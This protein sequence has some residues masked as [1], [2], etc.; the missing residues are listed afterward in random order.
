[1]DLDQFNLRSNNSVEA[2]VGDGHGGWFIGGAF[3]SVGGVRCPALAHILANASVDRSWCTKLRL[4]ALTNNASTEVAALVRRGQ[5]LLVGGYFASV[6]GKRRSGLAAVTISTGA[7][8]AW[9]PRLSEADCLQNC[10]IGS[11]SS[12]SVQGSKVYLA[13]FFGAVDG[14]KRY[15]LAAVDVHSGRE[16]G[17]NPTPKPDGTITDVVADGGVVYVSGSFTRVGGRHLDCFAALN[18]ATGKATSFRIPG[19]VLSTVVHK[20]ILYASGFI[21]GHYVNAFD[22]PSGRRLRWNPPLPTNAEREVPT[23]LDVSGGNVYIGHGF[24]HRYVVESFAASDGKKRLW[25]SPTLTN[26][27]DSIGISRSVIIL[28]GNFYGIVR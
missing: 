4:R 5:L 26:N 19:C 10:G 7:V 15:R 21:H 16:T 9:A 27:P 22:L 2:I 3:P 23:V 25:R 14:V 11:V 8:T 17:W 1:M 24:H 12:I 28:G 13:G 20:G 6:G 18:P